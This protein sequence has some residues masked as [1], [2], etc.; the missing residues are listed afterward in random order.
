[1]KVTIKPSDLLKVNRGLQMGAWQN[2]KALLLKLCQD[3]EHVGFTHLIA[4]FLARDA[5]HELVELADSLAST[6]YASATDHFVANQ[7][8]LLI[9]KYPFPKEI[10]PFDPEETAIKKFRK[11]EHACMRRNQFFKAQRSC[12]REHFSFYKARARSFIEYVLGEA[13]SLAEIYGECGFGPGAS[14]GVHG[15][16]TNAARKLL[17]SRWSVSPSA[18]HYARSA[19]LSHAQIREVLLP[20]HGGFSSGSIEG[21][22]T[23][24]HEKVELVKHNKIT[25]VPKTVKTYRSI[26]VEPLLNGFVQKGVDNVMR[27]RLKRIG[28]DLSNQTPNQEFARQGSLDSTT[29]GFCTIDLSAASDSIA[30]EVVRDLLPPDWFALLNAL[31]SKTYQLPDGSVRPFEKFASMGNGFCFPLETLLFAAACH[32]VAAGQPGKDFL[33]YGDD[34]VVRRKHF[35][36]VVIML[37]HLGFRTN[38][39]KTFNSGPFRE[40]C[41]A[42]W[43]GGE[44]VRPFTLDY[45][46]DSVENVFKFLNL[47][48]RSHR[49][50]GFF[51]GVRE[52]VVSLLPGRLR[53]Y[54]PFKGEANTGIDP[55]DDEY[56]SSPHCRFSS[57][58]RAWRWLELKTA[59]VSDDYWRS[60]GGSG[61]AALVF[62][63]LSGSASGKPFALRNIAKTRVRV[64]SHCGATSTWLPPLG[65]YGIP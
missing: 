10:N 61:V 28:I 60:F 1:M 24:F 11:S 16:G 39:D 18:F 9:K 53:F 20:D 17:A 52:F 2:Y 44:D 26:A 32:A 12:G 58:S 56:L 42:D 22:Y 46:L 35:V 30:T 54:R 43:F 49:S 8:S 29:E 41:G 27:K 63:A 31:R 34:I 14:I 13:P 4:D 6:E 19:V 23:S 45:A 21:D 51:R 25:F 48:R 40:S 38:S 62:G 65:G 3:Y 36:P 5:I 47:S 59:A 15:N 37:G 55:I 57:R 50:C 7:F 33:V 64:I